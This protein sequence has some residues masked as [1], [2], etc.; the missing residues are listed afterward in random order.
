MPP[1]EPHPVSEAGLA[2]YPTSATIEV[3]RFVMLT[4]DADEQ[5][6]AP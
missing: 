1:D 5:L 3:V 6:F 2:L 4:V